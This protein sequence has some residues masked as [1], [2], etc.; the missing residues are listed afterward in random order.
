ME[1]MKEWLYKD[2]QQLIT[3]IQADI[4]D[5]KEKIED[6]LNMKEK[7]TDIMDK[8]ADLMDMKKKI[9]RIEG[10]I[11]ENIDTLYDVNSTLS[12]QITNVSWDVKRQKAKCWVSYLLWSETECKDW[13]HHPET[14]LHRH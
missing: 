13:G 14:G 3:G 12:A 8:M 11:A 7:M 5:T 4:V 6:M 2:L 1:Q 9:L 10:R